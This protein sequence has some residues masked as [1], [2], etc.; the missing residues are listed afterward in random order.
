MAPTATAAPPRLLDIYQRLWEAFGPQHWWPGQTPFE[1]LVGA[2]LTQNTNW[3]NVE[4]AINNLKAEGLLSLS[5]LRA[6]PL[7]DLAALIRPAG[8]YNLKARRLMN[9]LDILAQRFGGDLGDLWRLPLEQARAALLSSQ[10]VGPETADCIL[11]YAGNLPSFVVD[12]YTFRV[13]GRHGLAEP[14]LDY[15][16][17]RARFMQ[18]LPSDVALY[19]EYHALLVRLG[20]DFCKK[21]QPRCAGCPLEGWERAGDPS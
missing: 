16:G 2:V 14:G 8:Y 9:L 18:A 21:G 5:A 20:K 6:L 13:L 17:L 7:D 1:V 4:R 15:H 19:N 3:G 11:L 12:A 10:G